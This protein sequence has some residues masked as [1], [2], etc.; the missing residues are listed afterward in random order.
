MKRARFY[1]ERVRE[2]GGLICASEA[3]PHWWN[4]KHTQRKLI[5]VE[6]WQAS[7]PAP[8]DRILRLP[9]V[10]PVRGRTVGAAAS[11]PAPRRS[12]PFNA[13]RF[14]TIHAKEVSSLSLLRVALFTTASPGD[15]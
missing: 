1:E 6:W 7:I 11:R 2:G 10:P 8:R 15:P 13:Q 5:S 9:F 12:S 3:E 14:P 4:R